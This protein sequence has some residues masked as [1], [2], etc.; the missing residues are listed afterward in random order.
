M[1]FRAFLLLRSLWAVVPAFVPPL[2]H[3][4]RLHY[5]RQSPRRVRRSVL[6]QRERF[7]SRR[8]SVQILSVAKC[9]TSGPG[10]LWVGSRR[11]TTCGRPKQ[12]RPA[13]LAN[14]K[15]QHAGLS[16]SRIGIYEWLC[17]LSAADEP[18]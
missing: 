4:L 2:A 7:A 13:W 15:K 12:S 18:G 14:L 5:R 16:P 8:G 17:D 9:M 1:F 11:Y 10:A 6:S 3:A